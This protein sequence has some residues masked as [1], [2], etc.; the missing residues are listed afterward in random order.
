[1]FRAASTLTLDQL[2]EVT[3]YARLALD[4]RFRPEDLE[5]TP[6]LAGVAGEPGPDEQKL[7]RDWIAEIQLREGRPVDQLEEETLEGYQRE[8]SNLV[9]KRVRLEVKPDPVR[10]RRLLEELRRLVPIPAH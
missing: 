2:L 1:M 8:L 5:R 10:G 9:Q 4:R 3:Y 6:I 7:A